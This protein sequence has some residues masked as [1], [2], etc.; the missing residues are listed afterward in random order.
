MRG[1]GAKEDSSGEPQVEQEA[2][3]ALSLETLEEEEQTSECGPAEPVDGADLTEEGLDKKEE[4]E[5]EH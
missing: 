4:G 1:E 2:E 5:E 3:R